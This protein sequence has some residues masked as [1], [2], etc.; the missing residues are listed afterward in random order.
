[1]S[2]AASRK[3]SGILDILNAFSGSRFFLVGDSGEQD[4]ELYSSIAAERHNQILA[5]FIRD[6]SASTENAQPIDDPTGEEIKKQPLGGHL[7]AASYTP[8]MPVQ[9]NL[10]QTPP[11]AYASNFS[12][13]LTQTSF[14]PYASSAGDSKISSVLK[15][16]PTSYASSFA[17]PTQTTYQAYIKGGK[18][19]SASM[20]YGKTTDFPTG[21]FDSKL[22]PRPEQ[23]PFSDRP[24]APGAS[25]RAPSDPTP[26]SL[27]LPSTFYDADLMMTSSP[28]ASSSRSSSREPSPTAS[29]I[30]L[31]G[32]LTKQEL[33]NLSPAERRRVELQERVY[34]AR[35]RVPSHIPLRVFT[36]P[37]ECVEAERILTNLGKG[38]EERGRDSKR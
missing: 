16:P 20:D 5:I 32:S 19:G 18:G 9:A 22:P 30:H 28:S 34:L 37:E 2:P 38:G 7:R 26:T 29:T 24:R 4:L 10:P 36:K 35:L 31:P 33:Q 13:A 15:T 6:A 8:G 21:Y 12:N 3:R 11:A 25:P 14:E 23:T 27:S 1:M 17:T